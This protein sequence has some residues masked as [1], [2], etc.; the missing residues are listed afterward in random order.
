MRSNQDEAKSIL[1]SDQEL[2]KVRIEEIKPHNA[3]IHLEPY[4][5]QWPAL[6]EREANRIRFI[7]G[8][9]VL[10]LEHIGSTSVPGLCAKPFIDM[11]MVVQ[12]SADEESYVPELEEAGYTLRVREPDWFEHRLFKGPDTEIK[13]HVF[14]KDAS[15]I[16]RMLRFRN[17][18][19][20]SSADRDKYANIKQQL[21]KCEWRYVQHYADAKSEII[22]EINQRAK[23]NLLE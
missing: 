2:Q 22:Q 16:D 6:F 18:L 7:L 10:Q 4:N 12:D 20:I 21:A 13:L 19:R 11:L 17:W 5:S 15:E 3:P 1:K 8:D 14:S 23:S 9:K